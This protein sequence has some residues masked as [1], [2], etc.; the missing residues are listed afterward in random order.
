MFHT[1]NE[2][3]TKAKQMSMFSFLKVA[4]RV[5]F[6]K[7]DDIDDSLIEYDFPLTEKIRI[8]QAQ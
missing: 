2:S 1:S 8:L 6:Q 7:A 4:R 5:P 3:L